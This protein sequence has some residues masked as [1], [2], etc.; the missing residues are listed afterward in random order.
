MFLNV[1][2]YPMW[3]HY[4]FFSRSCGHSIKPS[5]VLGSLIFLVPLSQNIVQMNPY[6]GV[7]CLMQPVVFFP[8]ATS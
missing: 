8:W 6:E 4:S 2:F 5:P 3:A 7:F 1:S